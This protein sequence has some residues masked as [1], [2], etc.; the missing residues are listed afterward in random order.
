MKLFRKSTDDKNIKSCEVTPI[1]EN[2]YRRVCDD[3]TAETCTL[4]SKGGVQEIDVNILGN[5]VKISVD[6]SRNT[7]N[8]RPD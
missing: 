1:N 8:C 7:T 2:T 3:G 5:H 6:T 4:E